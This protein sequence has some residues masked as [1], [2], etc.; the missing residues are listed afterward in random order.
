MF[1]QPGRRIRGQEL[2]VLPYGL[3]L[4]AFRWQSQ[5]VL[6]LVTASHQSRCS[7]MRDMNSI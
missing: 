1:A 4:L 3:A 2:A 6:V 5:H 7:L